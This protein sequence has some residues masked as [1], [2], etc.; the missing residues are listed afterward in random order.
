MKNHIDPQIKLNYLTICPERYANRK[1]AK[2]Y[3]QIVVSDGVSNFLA[4]VKA[5]ALLAILGQAVGAKQT[6][7]TIFGQLSWS[8]F[9]LFFEKSEE[10]LFAH[11]LR[12]YWMIQKK[13]LIQ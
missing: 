2:T 6:I 3:C 5:F 1:L 4:H 7:K 9:K 8:G 13:I 10:R 12:K 11:T